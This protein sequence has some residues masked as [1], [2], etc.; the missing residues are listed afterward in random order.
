LLYKTPKNIFLKKIQKLFYAERNQTL[1]KVV[2][3]IEK[4]KTN[5][6]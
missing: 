2:K 6:Q 1:L 5:A 4:E 3:F